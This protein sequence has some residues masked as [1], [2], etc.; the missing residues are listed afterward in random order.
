MRFGAFWCVLLWTNASQAMSKLTPMEVI[1][2]DRELT[3]AFVA[4]Q[5]DRQAAHG[6]MKAVAAA[7][8]N[9]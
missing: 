9:I 4:N 2:R 6:C 3:D 7:M 8:E 1:L 5:L